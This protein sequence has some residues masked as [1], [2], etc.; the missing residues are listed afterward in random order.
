[1]GERRHAYVLVG[2]TGRK[3]ELGRSRL[4]W[5]NNNNK[6]YFKEI[7]WKFV[8]FIE[9]AQVRHQWLGIASSVME[10]CVPSKREMS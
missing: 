4:K 2:R 8:D 1:M 5:E 3:R 7:E 9:L 6:L 10:L